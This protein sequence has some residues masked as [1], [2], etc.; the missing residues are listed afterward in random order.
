PQHA[1]R[2]ARAAPGGA[3]AGAG[4]GSVTAL[5]RTRAPA[6]EVAAV[7]AAGAL[8]GAAMA[9]AAAIVSL[10]AIAAALVVI[11]MMRPALAVPLLAFAVWL[12][13]PALAVDRHGVPLFAGALVPL[14]LVVPIAYGWLQ[15]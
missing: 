11:L 9:G 5:R 7:L 2:P 8:L 15:G 12:N 14:V 10:A 4:G 1:A 3:G 6:W 13:V